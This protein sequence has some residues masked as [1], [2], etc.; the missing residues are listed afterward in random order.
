GLPAQGRK[1]HVTQQAAA[2]PASTTLS[3]AGKECHEQPRGRHRPA[4]A[5]F[6][7]AREFRRHFFDHPL[8][9]VFEAES[10]GCTGPAYN[11]DMQGSTS[12]LP[13][14]HQL[15]DASIPRAT[16]CAW[17]SAAPSKMLRMRA[18]HSTR[19]M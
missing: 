18:S 19:L 15:I 10:E 5:G 6:F 11:R 8:C 14:A 2:A 4:S 7:F 13:V 12:V 3:L 17:I 16:T 1:R 9:L